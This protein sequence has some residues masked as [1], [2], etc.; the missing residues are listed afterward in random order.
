[1]HIICSEKKSLSLTS[2]SSLLIVCERRPPYR[3]RM[4]QKFYSAT[5]KRWLSYCRQPALSGSAEK[6]YW[7]APGTPNLAHRQGW[8]HRG[9]LYLYQLPEEGLWWEG[10][11]SLWSLPPLRFSAHYPQP[12]PSLISEAPGSPVS[13]VFT[14]EHRQAPPPCPAVERVD[15]GSGTFQ[16]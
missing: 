14:P 4:C 13:A 2:R 1:M 11:R 16:L 3:Q 15:A 9:F 10:G 5:S 7:R 6:L 8:N 12:C